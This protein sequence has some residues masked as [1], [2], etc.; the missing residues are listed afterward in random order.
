MS[1]ATIA[2]KGNKY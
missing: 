2:A 1:A